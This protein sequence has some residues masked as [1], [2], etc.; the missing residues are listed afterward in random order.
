MHACVRRNWQP[1]NGNTVLA[2]KTTCLC[3]LYRLYLM[4]WTCRYFK[5]DGPKKICLD[6]RHSECTMCLQ[7]ARNKLSPS[8]S[9]RLRAS[10]G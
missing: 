10:N 1:Q 2:N 5:N 8:P 7:E 4:E 9:G 3:R 6:V